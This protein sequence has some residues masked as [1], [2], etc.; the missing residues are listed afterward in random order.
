MKIKR[1]LSLILAIVICTGMFAVLPTVSAVDASLWE[2][3]KEDGTRKTDTHTAPEGYEHIVLGDTTSH[4]KYSLVTKEQYS[5]SETTIVMRDVYIRAATNGAYWGNMVFSNSRENAASLSSSS[6]ST[7][8]LSLLLRDIGDYIKVST[9]TSNGETS[10]VQVPESEEYRINF[11]EENGE[12]YMYIN[13]TSFTNKYVNA[14]C[15]NGDSYITTASNN[16]FCASVK[17]VNI[18]D[19]TEDDTED[20]APRYDMLE[21]TLVIEDSSLDS[22]TSWNYI[23][24]STK[25]VEEYSEEI[26]N[27]SDSNIGFFIAPGDDKK[28]LKISFTTDRAAD[29][30]I[31]DATEYKISIRRVNTYCYLFVNNNVVITKDAKGNASTFYNALQTYWTNGNIKNTCVT[32]LS[33][34]SSNVALNIVSNDEFKGEWILTKGTDAVKTDGQISLNSTKAVSTASKYNL[35]TE[36][37]TLKNAILSKSFSTDANRYLADFVVFGNVNSTGATNLDTSDR[38]II[39]IVLQP[40]TIETINE[41]KVIK[42]VNVCYKSASGSFSKLG[43]IKAADNYT[44]D[45]EKEDNNYVLYVNNVRFTSSVFNTLGNAG[46]FESCYVSLVTENIFKSYPEFAQKTG[47]EWKDSEPEDLEDTIYTCLDFADYTVDYDND[48]TIDGVE[49]AKG[50]KYNEIGDHKLIYRTYRMK[51]R[52]T[53]ALYRYG[54]LNTDNNVNLIDLVALKKYMADR[55]ELSMSGKKAADITSDNQVVADDLVVLRQFLINSDIFADTG[56]DPEKKI[57]A[58]SPANNQNITLTND[59]VY[60]W[61]QNHTVKSSSNYFGSGDIYQNKNTVFEWNE[62]DGATGYTLKISTNQSL[63]N[64]VEIETADNSEEVC[65][66]FAGEKYYWQVIAK[67]GGNDLVSNIFS[68]RTVPSPR[69]IYLEG[70][71]NTRDIG[72]YLTESGKRVKQ[73]MVYRSANLDDIT[74]AG[75]NT[76]KNIYNIKTDLDLRGDNDGLSGQHSPLTYIDENNYLHKSGAWYLGDNG[77]ETNGDRVKAG[78]EAFANPNNF[79]MVVHCAVGRDRT[80]TMCMLI[81]GLLG[82]SKEDLFLDFELSFFSV[83]GCKNAASAS[84]M[85]NHFNTTYN[86]INTT[87]KSAGDTFSARVEAY[88]LEIGVSQ[89]TIDAIK[90]NLLED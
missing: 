46:V 90:A 43:T 12:W 17:F 50:D 85:I 58:V 57:K 67:I 63:E 53:L 8:T 15:N 56:T 18:N 40:E 64:A 55:R 65:N 11:V 4:R 37:L 52:V 36:K 89:E 77:I 24:L 33:D 30:V 78:I 38:K 31:S 49:Y 72:G 69:T 76:A 9:Y 68:F 75:I 20:N 88:L 87:Y 42:T 14:L 3:W 35:V 79:P 22:L 71:S 28:G 2:N 41:V 25:S 74:E 51:Y 59:D 54:D 21:N 13:D 26:T 29:L 73:G 80:G 19:N 84:Q 23:N 48:V 61:S 27:Y 45:F 7:S 83:D 86:Y 70:V 47:D 60:Y 5:L 66:L 44:F 10:Q 39:S 32:V 16:K 34:D 6:T 62:I 81:N 1:I 82:V